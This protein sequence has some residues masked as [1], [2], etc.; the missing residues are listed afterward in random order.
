MPCG[1][2]PLSS[3][4]L[5]LRVLLVYVLGTGYAGPTGWVIC[6]DLYQ[7]VRLSVQQSVGQNSVNI[8]WKNIQN[9]V[10]I[11]KMFLNHNAS[12][13][14][15]Y[16]GRVSCDAQ[17]NS[18]CLQ[19][20]TQADEG[21]YERTETPKDG[22]QHKWT[23]HLFM[24]RS[25][26]GLNISVP[27]KNSSDAELT[28][29]CQAQEGTCLS[30]WWLKDG[31]P[32]PLDGRHQ[33]SRWNQTLKI[34]NVTGEDCV[35]YTCE[36]ANRL[37]LVAAWRVLSDKNSSACAKATFSATRT[38]A[39]SVGIICL[40]GFCLIIYCAHRH[41]QAIY[42][43]IRGQQKEE[44]TYMEVVDTDLDPRCP[45]THHTPG[46]G[47]DPYN[48]QELDQTSRASVMVQYV[49]ADILPPR[50]NGC[51][52]RINGD[53]NDSV[54]STIISESSL[55]TIRDNTWQQSSREAL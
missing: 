48:G 6:A 37:G 45:N 16:Q 8:E 46:E 55:R 2:C 15:K 17:C 11:T 32:L 18:L 51:I 24:L 36:G 23:V 43:W 25:P 21:N 28:L 26:V 30:Y 7:N 22:T 31:K 29:H 40:L 49:Y 19:N 38:L 34:V 33:L 27:S 13:F 1:A 3:T 10:V 54:Y 42:S 44:N 41:R 14:G 39:I 20:F 35:N 53:L 52:H 5:G 50:E 4:A 12:Y 47:E 9:Q